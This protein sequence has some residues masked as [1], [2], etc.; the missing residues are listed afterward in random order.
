MANEKNVFGKPLVLCCGNS[1]F[2]REGFCSGPAADLGNHSICAIV[3][4]PF[5]TFSKRRGNDLSAPKPELAF[6]GLSAG[7][8][9]CL[10]A[11][12]WLEAHQAG[13][14]PKVVLSATNKKALDIVPLS[15]L[16]AY[17]TEPAA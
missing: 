4:K 13:V 17:A 8:R 11:S 7:D 9:W 15:L 6:P 5:L 3:E 2:T 12:R 14:A 16:E 10:C 1:G